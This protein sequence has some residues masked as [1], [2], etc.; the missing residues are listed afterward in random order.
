VPAPNADYEATTTC[1]RWGRRFWTAI[2]VIPDFPSAAQ[3]ILNG[4]EEAT[5]ERLDGVILAD[6]FALQALLGIVDCL[7][8]PATAIEIDQNTVVSFTT[9][10]AYAQFDDSATRKRI[11]GERARLVFR[12]SLP[13]P[14]QSLSDL[15][16]HAQ[17]AA[18]GH[19]LV[20]SDHPAV[21]ESLSNVSIGGALQAGADDFL[22]VIVNSAGSK[23]DHYQ[24]RAISYSVRLPGG[25]QTVVGDG[26]STTIIRL[27]R[28]L[29]LLRCRITP[30]RVGN[31]ESS[32]ASSS[33]ARKVDASV[34]SWGIC[35]LPRA[36]RWSTLIA[37][38]ALCRAVAY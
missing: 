23:V 28:R 19:I 31:P 22:S 26:R 33:L 15:R 6:P 9:N 1:S 13:A 35:N 30:P 3:A 2:N 14:T 10:E 16:V 21:Q 32:S 36:W 11:P 25:G 34:R 37:R 4:Y 24:E 7:D 12:D 5:G 38:R 18:E 27:I 17:T 8:Y 29:L 20:H